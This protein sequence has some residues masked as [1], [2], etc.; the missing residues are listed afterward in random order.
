M[1]IAIPDGKVKGAIVVLQ[2]IFGVN[3]HIR[4]VCERYAAEGYV[5]A[6]PAIFD[7]LSPGYERGYEPDDVQAGIAMMKDF[8]RDAVMLDIGAAVDAVK[9]YGKVGIVGYCLGGSLAYRA[10]IT[11]DDLAAASCYYGGM[12]PDM[13]DHAPKCPTI[14]HFGETD[15]SIPIEK[16][17]IVKQ[18]RPDVPVYIYP[19]GHGFSCDARSAY[20][21]VSAK[22]A[23]ERTLQLFA[24]NVG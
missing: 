17:E 8:D 15:H 9:Q 24:E 16:A 10:A 4:S 3:A 5:A 1:Y 2:E 21:P 13:V 18:K 6:A 20:E 14:V 22:L 12:V 11:R 23:W 19:A 7:R